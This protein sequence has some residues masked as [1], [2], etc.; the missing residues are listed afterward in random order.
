M[1]NVSLLLL[2]LAMLGGCSGDT[3][4]RRGDV[5]AGEVAG[6]FSGTGQVTLPTPRSSEARAALAALE[7]DQPWRATL[8]MTPLL[9]DPA[10]RTPD[11]VLIAAMA[12]SRWEGWSTVRTLLE[13]APWLDSE[14]DACGRALLARAALELG[15]AQAAATHARAAV[16]NTRDPR[17]KAE[18][19]VVLARALDRLDER[20]GARDAYLAAARSLASIADWLALR[21][22]GVTSDAGDRKRLFERLT[23]APAKS[24]RTM[25]EAQARERSGDLAG[26]ADAF[27]EAGSPSNALRL[28]LRSVPDPAARSAI[29]LELFEE[30]AR[31]AGS[32]E[33]RA[34]VSVADS[35]LAPLTPAEELVVARSASA[36]GPASR[37]AD[38][39][40][41][42]L[43]AG[44]GAA[45]DW[46]KY[47]DVLFRLARYDRAATAYGRVTGDAAVVA[48]ANY[49]RGRALLRS[50]LDVQGSR[51]LADVVAKSPSTPAA[52]DAAYL[53]AD[54]RADNRGD[55]GA[56]AEF[57]SVA[58]RFPRADVAS[59]AAY[60]AALAAQFL[61]DSRSAAAELDALATE[62]PKGDEREGALYW[63]G[64]ALAARDREAARTRWRQ[65]I[66]ESPMSYYA[67]LAAKRLGERPWHPEDA[68]A[69][70]GAPELDAAL[71]RARALEALGMGVEARFELDALDDGA[72]EPAELVRVAAA[73]ARNGY[74]A[75]AVGLARRAL[76]RGAPRNATLIALLYPDPFGNVLESEAKSRGLDPALVASLVR[77]ESSFDP[78]ARSA[79]G[80]RGLMQL[81][82]PVAA[83]IARALDFPLW[84]PA[85]LYQPDVNLQLGTAHLA[86]L[87]K[88]YGGR[89]DFA[90]AAYN[91]G[92]S[93]V[94]RWRRL[95]GTNDPE[96]FV[97]RIP[98]EETREYV[99]V[100]ERGRAFY[101]R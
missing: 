80:A 97:E 29:R 76:A 17:A 9:R 56:R 45:G 25:T 7:R 74:T 85:L 55:A 34:L 38:G 58:R 43:A 26:A 46:M 24:R 96:V 15:D 90:L 4:A 88:E 16:Q 6:E 42:A 5:S 13:P 87:L 52:A 89:R 66:R 68:P 41:R 32:S 20:E 1:P 37:A 35:M 73:M 93:R 28:R 44:L 10:R 101:Q 12:A 60:R 72:R 83:S 40:A 71:R 39:F 94:T 48:R 33:S 95:P 3:P 70:P 61:G 47:G 92:G 77:Q 8:T 64:R 86:S 27:A 49:Q 69:L 99:K 31:R 98:F 84:D 51:V 62:H 79:V 82:P 65:V 54:V 18:R 78:R 21:A 2:P 57:L 53:L 91:A 63:A 22:A 75:R 23:L 11:A 19:Q 81:M 100:V 50:G 14:A 59:R 36:S 67:M 30:I